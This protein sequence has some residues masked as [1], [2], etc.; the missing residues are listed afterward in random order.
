MS[1]LRCYN[2]NGKGAQSSL[3]SGDIIGLIALESLQTS[4]LL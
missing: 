4:K 3:V 1:V 2:G